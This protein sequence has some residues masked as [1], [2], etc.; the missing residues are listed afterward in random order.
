[1]KAYIDIIKKI[2]SQGIV[3]QNRTGQDALT[4]A[5]AMF[6]HDMEEGFPLLTTKKIPFRLV[7]SEL[8]FF[9]KGYTDK[10]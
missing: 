6:E 5:G 4:I 8:E 1:M 3:K 2:L 7:S 10:N 9:L